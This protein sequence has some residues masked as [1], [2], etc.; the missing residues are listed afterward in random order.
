M[1]QPISFKNIGI[2]FHDS[3]RPDRITITNS[4]GR[5]HGEV[6]LLDLSV[7]EAAQL[8]Q[9]LAEAVRAN[10]YDFVARKRTRRS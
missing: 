9:R 6:Q 10:G 4:A 7:H 3:R 2:T 8:S 1:A 5:T